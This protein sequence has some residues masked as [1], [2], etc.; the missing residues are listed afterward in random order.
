MNAGVIGL[1]LIGLALG[2]ASVACWR[3]MLSPLSRWAPGLLSA[4]YY[5]AMWIWPHEAI[6]AARVGATYPVGPGLRLTLAGLAL[7]LAVIELSVRLTRSVRQNAALRARLAELE[8][9]DHDD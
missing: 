6:M 9:G 5:A 1:L 3:F 4:A 8:R 2:V 7:V